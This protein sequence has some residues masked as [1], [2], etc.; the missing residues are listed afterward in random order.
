MKI[1]TTPA[2]YTG[3]FSEVIYTITEAEP[4]QILEVQ[5]LGDTT[6]DIIGIKR[7]TGQSEYNV[8]ISNYIRRRMNAKPVAYGFSTAYLAEGRLAKARIKVGTTI[9]L[10]RT[11]TSGYKGSAQ[12]VIMSDAPFDQCLAPG[13]IDEASIIGISGKQIF[14]YAFLTKEGTD[15]Y[16]HALAMGGMTDSAMSFQINANEVVSKAQSLSLGSIDQYTH[17]ELCLETNSVLKPFRRYALLPKNNNSV[18]MCWVNPYGALDYYTF[19]KTETQSIVA[20]RKKIYSAD[21]YK[22]FGSYSEKYITVE[23]EYENAETIMW[24]SSIIC[25]PRAWIY[26]DGAFAEVDIVT[27][28]IS[29]GSTAPGSVKLTLREKVRKNYQNF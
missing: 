24:L 28:N 1:S 19:G 5:I 20:K 7:F 9:S 11:F 16:E 21:G 12:N 22:C 29:S 26:A 27:E 23:S 4:D 14:M 25:S 3:A 2:N 8:N 6:S 18:R 10:Q 17:L 15:I 13:E